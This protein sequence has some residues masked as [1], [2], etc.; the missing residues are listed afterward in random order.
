MR[1]IETSLFELMLL[2]V[3]AL[4]CLALA[5]AY[6]RTTFAAIFAVEGAFAFVNA[7]DASE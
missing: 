1:P 7:M 4:V 6:E 5:G 2:C 3:L